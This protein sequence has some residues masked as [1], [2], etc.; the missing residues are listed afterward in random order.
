MRQ[1]LNIS[2]PGELLNE[3]KK[4]VKTGRYTSASE[5]IRSLLREWQENKLLAG[6]KESQKEARSGKGRVLRSLKDS[7]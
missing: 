1:I 4:E 7:R 6:L 5:F 2:L 3:V